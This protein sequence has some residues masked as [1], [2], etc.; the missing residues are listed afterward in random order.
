MCRSFASP[1]R[2]ARAATCGYDAVGPSNRRTVITDAAPHSEPQFADANGLRLCYD[3]FGV[4]SSPPVILIMGFATQMILW[5]EDFCATL[6][7]RGFFV[8]RFDNRD[9]GLSTKLEGPNARPPGSP[10]YAL[11]DMARDTFGLMDALGMPN[12]HVV[13]LSM[14]GMIAQ[15]MAMLAPERL[16]SLTSIM[17]TT[18]D[19]KLP[20][21]TPAAAE[22]LM[23]P[24]PLDR[25]SFLEGYLVA[26][27]VFNGGRAPLDE[28]NMRRLGE[29]TYDRGVNPPGVLRQMAAIVASGN[30]APA[31]REVRI[32]TLV[33]HGEADPLVPISGGR[34]TAE[35]IP[36]AKLLVLDDM[37]H[38]MLR[39]FW[40]QIIAAIA[41]H[42]RAADGRA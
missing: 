19:P 26:W 28:T 10:P 3:T 12:A 25:E 16:R 36:N 40:P 29:L 5:E 9:V 14:G 31:L 6:A 18:G 4:P 39:P 30:R 1:R 35:A 42:A 8:V 32:P 22:A 41:D 37:G 17:S 24:R 21:P 33:I 20:G 38:L 11:R 13:G 2:R 15:E 23:R 27:R 7:A 34:A